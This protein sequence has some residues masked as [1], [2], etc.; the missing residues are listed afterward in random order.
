MAARVVTPMAAAAIPAINVERFIIGYSV[1]YSGADR[2]FQP[3]H[4]HQTQH[5]RHSVE[6]NLGPACATSRRK[7]RMRHSKRAR[8]AP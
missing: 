1:F 6:I 4:T 7:D 8:T 2:L 3:R 5:P